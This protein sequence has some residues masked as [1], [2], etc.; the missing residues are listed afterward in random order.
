M[1]Q[2]VKVLGILHIAFSSLGVLAAILVPVI[3]SAIEQFISVRGG[4]LEQ[5]NGLPALSAIA[6]V[7]FIVLMVISL[8]GLIGGIGLL[9]YRPWARIL[10]IV[11]SALDLLQFP[12]GTALGVYGFW[13]LLN[14]ETETLFG[15]SIPTATP[16]RP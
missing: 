9:Y 14:R 3:L 4:T 16:Q 15:L 13:V 2:H 8:P 7:A 5:I 11:L 12:L 10:L 1:T 6:F